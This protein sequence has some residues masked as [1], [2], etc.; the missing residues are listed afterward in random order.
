VHAAGLIGAITG[1]EPPTS[2]AGPGT[3]FATIERALELLGL[4]VFAIS[5]GMLA[6]RKGFEVVGVTALAYTTAL[7]GG[8]IRD[9][10]LGDAP[11]RAFRDV[12]YVLVPFGA[13]VVVFLGH[14]L[15]SRGLHRSV[16][17]FDAAGLGLFTVTGAAKAAAYPTTAVGAVLLAVVTAV[18]GGI[19]R[20]VLANDQPQL[21]QAH[22]RLYAI[23]ATVGAIVVVTS[24]RAD[25]YSGALGAAVAAAVCT[26]RI[27]ALQF[28]WRAPMPLRP[29][30]GAGQ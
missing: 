30:D 27:A 24:V 3:G 6:V 1:V 23:P 26:V 8:I 7:G 13:A 14:S 18:G 25:W 22:S 2:I 19:L 17:L 28:G 20:D 15:I 5:G 12:A 16:Q 4:F 29:P 21:F 10:V 9:L 11:P